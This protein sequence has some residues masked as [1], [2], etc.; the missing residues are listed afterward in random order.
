MI[1]P[2]VFFLRFYL[3]LDRGEG[4]EKE[5]ERNISVCLPLTGPTP[6]NLAH[7]PGMCP[8]RESNQRPFGSQD[9]AQST[10]PHWPGPKGF[11]FTQNPNKN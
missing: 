3:F 10:K 8:D 6:G 9:G 4:R 5:R 2:K 7:N 11:L 1:Y